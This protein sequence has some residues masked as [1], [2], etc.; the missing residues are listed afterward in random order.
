MIDTIEVGVEFVDPGVSAVDEVDGEVGVF[1]NR[2][3]EVDTERPTQEEE[4]FVMEY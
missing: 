2:A 1:V 3:R 4:Y